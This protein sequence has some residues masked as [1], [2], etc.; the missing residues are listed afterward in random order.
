MTLLETLQAENEAQ[1][2]R[3]LELEDERDYLKAQLVD[4]DVIFPDRWRFGP[5]PEAFLRCLLKRNRVTRDA[6][7]AAIYSGRA[8]DEPHDKILDVFLHRVREALEPDGI[9][10]DTRRGRGWEI[11]PDMKA[12][13]L[14]FCIIPNKTTRAAS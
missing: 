2:V 8:G 1:A 10:I 4:I 14:S 9:K 7:M 6:A 12:K 13:L 5:K 3:I 11:R